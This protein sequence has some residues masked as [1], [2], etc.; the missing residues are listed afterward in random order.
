MIE[1][2]AAALS[3]RADMAG[4]QVLESCSS[5]WIFD[6]ASHRF[7]CVPRGAPVSLAVPA[8]WTEYHVLDLDEYRSRFTVELDPDGTRLLRVSLHRDPCPRCRS[9]GRG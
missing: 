2:L 9:V 4:L 1:H 3:G 7:R 8:R 6:V 5:T